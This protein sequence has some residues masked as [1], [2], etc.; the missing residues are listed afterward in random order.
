MSAKE[1]FR[2]IELAKRI[3]PKGTATY[4][5]CD[6]CI[7]V[8]YTQDHQGEDYIAGYCRVRTE[9]ELLNRFHG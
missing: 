6:D 1:A 5:K 4:D 3:Y 8:G 2:I 9:A 7:V